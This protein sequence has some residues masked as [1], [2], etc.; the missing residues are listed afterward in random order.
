[1]VFYWNGT[2]NGSH[3][4]NII[5]KINGIYPIK[6]ND[7]LFLDIRINIYKL[8]LISFISSSRLHTKNSF[9]TY[10]IYSHYYILFL[11]LYYYYYY[12][13]YSHCFSL[14]DSDT[15]HLLSL[16]IFL[17]LNSH[18]NLYHYTSLPYSNSCHHNSNNRKISHNI[19]LWYNTA[20]KDKNLS[21][22]EAK[23]LKN[24]LDT[25]IKE[26]SKNIPTEDKKDE[27]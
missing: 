10:Q 1:M 5:S 11:Y 16:C 23:E 14:A 13:S 7:F 21:A 25:G 20:M 3:L 24:I 12:I 26:I 4:I 19:Y 18:Y 6:V 17:Y 27:W 22:R 15:S 8:I 9:H 2:L